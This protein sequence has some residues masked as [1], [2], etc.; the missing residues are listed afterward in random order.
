MWKTW[1]ECR[2]GNTGVGARSGGSSVDTAE[3]SMESGVTGTP[4]LLTCIALWS[5]QHCTLGS[6]IK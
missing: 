6:C 4:L 2:H 1:T 3:A 5:K